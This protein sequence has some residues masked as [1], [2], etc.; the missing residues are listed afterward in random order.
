MHLGANLAPPE[1]KKL[2]Y[3]SSIAADCLIRRIS[4]VEK[5]VI[6][7]SFTVALVTENGQNW[8]IIEKWPFN[9]KMAF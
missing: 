8:L 1:P 9:T 5:S 2:R 4:Q 3:F 7:S 6:Y